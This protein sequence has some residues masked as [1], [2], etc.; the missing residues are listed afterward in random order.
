MKSLA[1]SKH[2]AGGET[3]AGNQ[4]K[5]KDMEITI[6]LKNETEL[7]ST[8]GTMVD[9]V[10]KEIPYISL[11]GLCKELPLIVARTYSDLASSMELDPETRAFSKKMIFRDG[12]IEENSKPLENL[13]ED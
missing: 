2:P 9:V 8:D 12:L 6:S 7:A 11:N 4:L 13:I 3:L 1:E 10:L 5:Q